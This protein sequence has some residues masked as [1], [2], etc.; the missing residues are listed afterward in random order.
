[1]ETKHIILL[2]VVIVILIYFSLSYLMYLKVFTRKGY[3]QIAFVDHEDPFFAE[4]KA[5]YD[6][7]PKEVMKIHGYDGTLLTGVFLP[8]YDEKSNNIAIVMHGYQSQ[9]TDMIFIARMYNNMGFKVM[10]VDQRGHGNSEGSRTGFG[11]I[12]RYDLRKWIHYALRTY[13]SQD[14]ILLHG[15]S[16][17]AATVML[18]ANMA[19]PN[20]VKLVVADCGFTTLRKLFFHTTH[21]KIALALYPGVSCINFYFNRFFLGSVSPLIAIRKSKLPLFLIHGKMD[22]KVP[23]AMAEQLLETSKA[24]FKELFAVDDANHTEAFIKAKAALEQRL[25]IVIK[26]FF[27]IHK[28]VIKQMK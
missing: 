20:N 9:A 22:H 2:I 28:N 12:E 16:M 5:W 26:K 6:R 24:P 19:L 13:G 11:Q 3:G 15:V 8:S 17:G 14:Q 27:S 7:A 21:P 23:F 4:S 18:A 1:M 25:F 10:M